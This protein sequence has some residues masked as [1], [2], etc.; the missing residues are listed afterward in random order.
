[1]SGPAEVDR[2]R[3]AYAQR[4]AAAGASPYRFT[5]PAYLFHMQDLEWQVLRELRTAGVEI[6]GANV[7]EVGSG[8]GQ[9]LHR[10]REFGAARAAG[11]EL[12]EERAEASK[13]RYPTL[14]I[15]AGDASDLPFEDG[16]FDLVTQFTC[17]SSVLDP[18]LRAAIAAEMWRV[19]A[20]GGAVL[21]YDMRP[22][23]PLMR[24]ISRALLGGG[25][26]GGTPT[27][28]LAPQD[29]AGLFPGG[30][31]K[32]RAVSLHFELAGLSARSRLIA[33]L[34]RAIPAV[35]T[36]ALVLVRKPA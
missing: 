12:S 20:P 4:D 21:S 22:S 29:V 24:A 9:I 19:L 25:E 6:A 11:V 26:G 8:F 13:Q 16:S 32:H 23:P 34:L 14:E 30:Q 1:M 15:I 18:S 7:L 28:A 31:A 27:V 33:G 2:I 5:N 36:H 3:D 35:R 17:L 10:L